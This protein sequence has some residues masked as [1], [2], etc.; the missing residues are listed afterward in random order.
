M[1][2]LITMAGPVI[3][4]VAPSA[5]AMVTAGEADLIAAAFV[6]GPMADSTVV[7][8]T[9]VGSTAAD[10]T[11]VARMVVARMAVNGK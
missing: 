1:D 8:L 2:G 11:V 10:L 3:M 6:A 4:G 5:A 9:A 7:A